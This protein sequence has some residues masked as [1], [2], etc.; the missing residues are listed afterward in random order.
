MICIDV[1]SL[2]SSMK[3]AIGPACNGFFAITIMTVQLELETKELSFEL[4]DGL[5]LMDGTGTRLVG[6]V[7]S[8]CHTFIA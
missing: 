5:N 7:L 8:S 3:V 4:N 6:S 2:S 1:K